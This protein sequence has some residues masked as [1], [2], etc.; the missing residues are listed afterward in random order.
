[1]CADYISNVANNP[2]LSILAVNGCNELFLFHTVQYQS[3]NLFCSA[4][5]LL[6][7]LGGSTRADFYHLDP[8]SLFQD[9]EIQTP[10][11]WELKGATTPEAANLLQVAEQNPSTFKGKIGP[12]C[13]PLVLTTILEASA[14][15]LAQLI[16]ILLEK[17]RDFDRSSPTVKACTVLHPVL[18]YLWAIH[19]SLIQPIIFSMDWST[20]GQDWADRMHF[21]N[22]VPPAQTVLPMRGFFRR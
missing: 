5:K 3:Q 1:L 11:W 20:D 16:P 10:S 21:T 12:H 7:L 9:V 6:G 13:S 2:G 8:A 14:M 4:S 15:D 19:K 18:E 22:L 17:L